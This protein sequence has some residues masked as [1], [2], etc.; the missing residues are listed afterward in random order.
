MVTRIAFATIAALDVDLL[1][2]DEVLA[3]GDAAFQRKCVR[4]LEDYR[5]QGGSLIFVSHNLGLVRS[6]TDQAIWLDHGKIVEVGRTDQ[7]LA[8]YGESMER[9]DTEQHAP[10]RGQVK[11]L[12]A[13]RGLRR[14]GRAARWS[15]GYASASVRSTTGASRSGSPSR[16]LS[17]AKGS[18]GSASWTKQAMTWSARSPLLHL[19]DG[20]GEVSCELEPLLRNGLYFPSSRSHPDGTVRDHW[21]L[22]RPIVFE[23]N[24]N[25]TPTGVGAVTIP[26]RWTSEETTEVGR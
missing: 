1:L 5:A 10:G 9:R 13:D 25:G 22:D 21:Q 20:A 3:V 18:C 24:G 4:W 6:M 8:R 11:R 17:S 14:W 2:V 23:R 15:S 16:P 19:G 7:I 12:L 26:S